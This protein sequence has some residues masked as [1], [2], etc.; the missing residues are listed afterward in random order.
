MT[1]QQR[2]FRPFNADAAAAH[3]GGVALED[4]VRERCER[5]V[6]KPE[7]TALPRDVIHEVR[8]HEDSLRAVVQL[9]AAA[10][11]LRK[12]ATALDRDV[13]KREACTVTDPEDTELVVRLRSRH[14]A[15]RGATIRRARLNLDE[16]VAD[17]HRRMDGV[18]VGAAALVVKRKLVNLVCA[19]L[20][21]VA[22]MGLLN[23]APQTSH[24]A[25]AVL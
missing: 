18:E 3:G 23:C 25:V 17:L 19:H 9:Y 15:D 5:A 13:L 20:H 11:A 7:P 8:A 16:L 22:R 14:R 4:G 1:Q 12:D 24:G 2:R 6:T 10:L 21:H